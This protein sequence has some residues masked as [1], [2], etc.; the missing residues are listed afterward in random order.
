MSLNCFICNCGDCSVISKKQ[1]SNQPWFLNGV[2]QNCF[3]CQYKSRRL[4]SQRHEAASMKRCRI[5]LETACIPVSYLLWLGMGWKMSRSIGCMVPCTSSRKDK[6]I[7]RTLGE[8]SILLNNVNI[9]CLLTRS[10]T[11]VKSMIA[12]Y[13]GFLCFRHFSCNCISEKTISME[14]PHYASKL[15]LSAI[16][17]NMVITT[18]ANAFPTLLRRDIPQ[19]GPQLLQYSTFSLRVMML[20]SRMSWGTIAYVHHWRR[21]LTWSSRMALV[22][23]IALTISGGGCCLC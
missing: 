13:S 15:T 8:H 14:K 1:L 3:L 17:C 4:T 20:A 23:L 6:I 9:S 16:F 12:M 22:L 2:M 11:F 7:L 21:S 18:W 19:S 5:V 10:K